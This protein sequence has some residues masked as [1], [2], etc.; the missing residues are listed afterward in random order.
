[1]TLI[2]KFFWYMLVTDTVHGSRGHLMIENNR[3]S[4]AGDIF[5][6]C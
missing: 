6:I 2:H 5:Y 3:H 4:A 1:M